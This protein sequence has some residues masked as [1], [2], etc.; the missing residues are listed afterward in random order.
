MRIT[1]AISSLRCGGAERILSR[2]AS[3]WAEAG[4]DVT[5]MLLCSEQ[6][7][8][9]YPVSSGVRIAYVDIERQSRSLVESLRN[10]LRRIR[11][12]RDAV[13]RSNPDV[14]ISFIDITNIRILIA[15]LG[16]DIPIIV[17]ERI[18]PRRHPIGLAWSF[19]RR[20]TYPMAKRIV[21]QTTGAASY[22]DRLT[23]RR[24]RVIPN[25]TLPHETRPN[26]LRQ[27]RP[28]FLGV[29]RLAEQK[30]FDILLRAFHLVCEQLP[31]WTLY[32]YGEGP[33]RGRLEKLRRSLGLDDRVFFPG[34]VT[35][36]RAAYSNADIFVMSSDYEGY[37]NALCEAMS[38]GLA[39]ISTDC[40]S[41]PG[42]IV[43]SGENGLLVPVG[44]P[45]ALASTM[46]RL[47]ESATT[48]A[49]LGNEARRLPNE[50]SEERIMQLWELEIRDVLS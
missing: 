26:T 38:A 28:C 10:N 30:R 6:A 46:L 27:R 48:R 34:R 45:Q 13:F 25:P 33:L 44:E 7:P 22:F 12:I 36:I 29:G 32:I 11:Q 18:D 8:R 41:G 4:H 21:V 19:L 14:V 37:P 42:D 23:R 3:Y 24:V 16:T 43:R 40:P 31:E 17:S 39:C 50:R 20:M 9:F 1:L 47:A 5:L 15:L 2:M 35:D 49:N